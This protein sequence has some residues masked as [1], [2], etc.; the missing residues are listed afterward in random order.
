M[1][2]HVVCRTKWPEHMVK[3]LQDLIGSCVTASSFDSSLID[4][5][6]KVNYTG[7]L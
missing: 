2:R 4:S 3:V 5:C 6:G 7:F 1:A